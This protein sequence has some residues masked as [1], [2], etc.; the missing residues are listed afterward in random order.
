MQGQETLIL[1]DGHSVSIVEALTN[2]PASDLVMAASAT[3]QAEY[4][5]YSPYLASLLDLGRL[6][7]SFRVAN[8]QYIPALATAVGDELT[9][10]LN[11]PPS[12]QNPKSVLV[13]AL[14]AIE[15]AVPPPLHAVSPKD[16]Y[17]AR[18][19]SLVLPVE[20]APLVFSTEYA[21]GTYLRVTGKNGQAIDLAATADATRGGFIID[22]TPLQSASLE[23]RFEGSLHGHWGFEKFDG[24]GFQLVNAQTQ[25]WTPTSTDDDSIIVGRANT[26]HLQA[27]SVACID[28]IMVKDPT[29]KELRVEW[30]PVKANEVQINLP[31]QQA[32]AG[33]L[34]LLVSQFGSKEPHPL[35][36]R[37]YPEAGRFESFAIH[38]GESHGILKGSRLADVATLTV[39]D[40]EFVPAD[41]TGL[42]LGSDALRM[43]IKPATNIAPAETVGATNAEASSVAVPALQ[44]GEAP[45]AK[46]TLRDG[47]AFTVAVSVA[48]PRPSIELIGKDV[49]LTNKGDGSN[50]ELASKNQLPQDAQLVFSVRA[51]SPAQFSREATLEVA[52]EDEAFSASL[53]VANRGLM[54]SNT[55]VA[56]A[57]FD[58]A[59]AFGSSAFGPLKFR[60]VSNGVAGDWTQLVTL[61]RLPVL[62]AL[63]CPAEREQPCK[64]TGS[65]L[66]LVDSVSGHPTFSDAMEVPAGFPGRALPV[67]RPETDKLYIKLRDDPAVINVAALS[68]EE[69]PPAEGAPATAPPAATNG[70]SGT[71]RVG[72][73]ST[74]L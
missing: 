25:A 60:V 56:V 19:N 40:L 71:E 36:L 47:R 42:N 5:Y 7:D 30:S 57:T 48:A 10:R 18:R 63:Q 16:I 72:N 41:A 2:G 32:Q 65:N 52:S 1:N 64:L 34:T 38:A 3:P 9:L 13:A 8:Y 4:G 51:K 15:A 14:P 24:P 73:S 49:Q 26:I 55:R 35:E 43:E 70:E 20:G 53:S 69:L 59:K 12:F 45:R 74:G 62:Q 23:D 28:R 29:G 61:V 67:P 27:G 54:L 66:F 21:H 68:A 31:L 22:T 33:P 50:I 37:A 46:V 39:K 58:P 6:F 17:C 11:T 44:Q